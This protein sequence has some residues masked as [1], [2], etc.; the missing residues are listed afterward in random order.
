[1]FSGCSALPRPWDLSHHPSGG[2]PVP[3]K[4]LIPLRPSFRVQRC[5]HGTRGSLR[6]HGIEGCALF[7]GGQWVGLMPGGMPKRQQR[8]FGPCLGDQ[9]LENE[10]DRKSFGVL[11]LSWMPVGNVDKESSQTLI[12]DVL[13]SLEPEILGIFVFHLCPST[14]LL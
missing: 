12:S 9:I 2:G 5:E 7:L 8:P 13:A 4:I 3:S 11:S 6:P 14:T 10:E 1:M